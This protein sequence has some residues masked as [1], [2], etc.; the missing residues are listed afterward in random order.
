MGPADLREIMSG[1][2]VS[3]RLH[4]NVL[5]GLETSDDAGGFRVPGGLPPVQTLD[6]ITPIVDDP[7]EYGRIA[8]ANSLSDVY[9][10]GGTPITCLNICSFPSVGIPK[11][12]LRDILR[13]AGATI[14]EAGAVLLGGHTVTDP[15]LK[16]GLSVTGTVD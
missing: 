13:G 3:A 4:P 10:M 15:E 7:F 16:F 9:A 8:A 11:E 6:L 2:G 1:L 14:E 5:V 12:S